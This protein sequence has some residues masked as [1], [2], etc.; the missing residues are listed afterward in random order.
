MGDAHCDDQESSR[1]LQKR[2]EL[3]NQKYYN[4]IHAMREGREVGHNGRPS[5]LLPPEKVQ[6]WNWVEKR[7]RSGDPPSTQRCK[8]M[9]PTSSGP[10]D[11]PC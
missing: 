10:S 5:Y 8:D 6:F 1:E 11:P 2:L 4:A 7:T 3:S 9:V